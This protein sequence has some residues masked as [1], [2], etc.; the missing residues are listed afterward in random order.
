MKAPQLALWSCRRKQCFGEPHAPESTSNREPWLSE[1]S[2]ATMAASPS[3]T[4]PSVNVRRRGRGR[5]EVVQGRRHRQRGSRRVS[6]GVLCVSWGLRVTDTGVHTT[7]ASRSI[8]SAETSVSAH[9][10]SRVPRCRNSAM[11]SSGS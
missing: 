4:K 11:N 8:V 9:V 1:S 6:Q 5:R 3:L 2:Q 10:S 7:R